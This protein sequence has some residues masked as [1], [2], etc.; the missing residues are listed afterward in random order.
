MELGLAELQ[1]KF[2][3]HKN[4]K[5]PLCVRF[6]NWLRI[7][8]GMNFPFYTLDVCVCATLQLTLD[9]LVR[10]TAAAAAFQGKVAHEKLASWLR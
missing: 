7:I 1:R 4:S 10:T 8:L 2:F 3:L 9:P 6:P 5:C